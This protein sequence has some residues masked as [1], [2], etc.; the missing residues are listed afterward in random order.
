[1]STIPNIG[2]S[3]KVPLESSMQKQSLKYQKCL[4]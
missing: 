4:S 3:H 2:A 1:M